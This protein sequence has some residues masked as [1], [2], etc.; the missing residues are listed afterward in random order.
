[1]GLISYALDNNRPG[2]VQTS[3][4][5]DEA[6]DRIIISRTQDVE[7]T[8]RQNR[9]MRL[10]DDGY[11][12][13]RTMK[14]VGRIPLVVIEQIMKGDPGRNNGWDPLA[15]ENAERLLQLLDDPEYAHFKTSDG[16]VAHRP[17]RH[18]SRGGVSVRLVHSGDDE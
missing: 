15:E 2:E 9:E 5:Y 10:V 17:R 11:T 4:H 8:L 7:H 3:F 12:K 13:D 6:D 16:K 18:Y 1:M 14:R